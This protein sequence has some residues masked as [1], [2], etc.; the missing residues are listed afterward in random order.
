MG[1]HAPQ[2]GPLWFI[3]LHP[4][5]GLFFWTPAFALAAVGLVVA[6]RT[7]GLARVYGA[8]GLWA[9]ASYLTFNAGYYLWWGGY[10]MGP[11]HLLPAMAALPLGLLLACRPQARRAWWL[12]LALGAV[13]VV[14]SLPVALLEPETPVVE[15]Y[16]TL[17][18]ATP[19]TPLRATQLGFWKT[20]VSGAALRSP[21][22]GIDHLRALSWLTAVAAPVLGAC[23]ARRRIA[24]IGGRTAAP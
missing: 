3:T 20:V 16:T 11:R 24:A 22:G 17:R 10:A 23:W 14:L 12:L 2:L 8:L 18:H 9:L 21:A 15:A 5:R 4:H 7:P 19:S 13:G 1:I 6:L